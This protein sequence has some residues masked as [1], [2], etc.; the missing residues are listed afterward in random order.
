MATAEFVTQACCKKIKRDDAT[1]NLVHDCMM[2][3]Q[4]T[5]HATAMMAKLQSS[6]AL[7]G[8]LHQHVA[9]NAP[10]CNSKK[11]GNDISRGDYIPAIAPCDRDR[12]LEHALPS[13]V[14]FGRI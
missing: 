10:L 4:A 12:L 8:Q 5:A 11:R 13:C 1:Q 7:S 14:T 9:S 2:K 6:N 3:L